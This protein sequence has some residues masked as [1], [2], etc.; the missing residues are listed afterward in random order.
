MP[1]LHARPAP[2]DGGYAVRRLRRGRA[3]RSGRSTTC[4]R[5]R[6]TCATAGMALCVDLVL[7]HTAAEH[8]V[9]RATPTSTARSRTGREPD[10]YERTLPDVFPDTAPG[11]VH[12]VRASSGAGSGRRSTPTSGTSTTRTRTCSWRWPRRCSALAAGRRRRPAPGRRA[13]PVEAARHELPEPARGPRAAAGLPG[14]AADRRARGRLQ[15]RGDRRARRPRPLPGDGQARGQGVRPRL[16]Q[17]ADGAAVE[18]AGVA[19]AWR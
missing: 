2:N 15:G 14:G 4:A 19:A 8:A 5:W 17:R 9:D 7:N 10:A 13:V 18:R 16:P 3:R 6:P 11:L 12:V 1:L